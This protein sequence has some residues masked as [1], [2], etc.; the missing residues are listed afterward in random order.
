ML[1]PPLTLPFQRFASTTLTHT[2]PR[3]HS[4]GIMLTPLPGATACKP[5]AAMQPFFGIQVSIREPTTG[6]VLEGACEGV[7]VAEGTW[8]GIT[9]TV[10]N[11]HQ[12]YL[13]VYM[14]AVKGT[15]FFGD[16][17]SRDKDG[18][19]W[20]Q[21]RCDGNSDPRDSQWQREGGVIAPHTTHAHPHTQM[22]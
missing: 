17:A 18:H 21:G 1:S 16:S 11:N 3:N 2:T 8:P 19:Y 14:T 12:R 10:Y 5:G 9:R 22:S 13:N 15:Y 4:G 6:K 7:I 20:I